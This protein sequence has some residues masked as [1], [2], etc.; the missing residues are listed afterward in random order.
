MP[1]ISV[2]TFPRRV[3]TGTQNDAIRRSFN[4]KARLWLGLGMACAAGH[5]IAQ[6]VIPLAAPTSAEQEQRR[7]E[8]R[9]RALRIQQ[10]RIPD[11]RLLQPSAVNAARFQPEAPCFVIDQLDLK[12]FADQGAGATGNWDWA[13]H[14]AAGATHDDSPLR[15]CIGTAGIDLVLKRVQD[16]VVARG[17]VTTRV[18][19]EPQDLNG[20]VLTLTV[21]PGYISA[22]RFT[23][24]S[25]TSGTHLNAVPAKPGDVLNLRDVEQA[26]EN[27]KRVPT[28]D[29]DIQ[30]E[31]AKGKD[32]QPGQ[33]DLVISYK[34]AFPVRLSIF[35]DDSGFKSTGRYQGGISLSYDNPLTLN[36]LFYVSINRDLG[37]GLSGA[38][39]THGN[40]VHYSVPLGYWLIGVTGSRSR[41]RQS[42]AGINQTYLYS[43]SSSNLEA[44]LSRLVYRDASRKTTVA[45]RAFQR[46]SSNF[47][48]DTEVMVQRRVVGGYEASVNH[49]EFIGNAT[50]DLNL[51]YRRGTGAFG[52][53]AAPE[54]A[55]GEGTSR[56]R[57]TTLDATLNLP[58]KAMSQSLR[59]TGTLRTQANHTAL[60]PQ[61][62]FAIGGRYT[63]RGFDGET[64]LLAERGVLLRN[65]LG[66]ALG[67]SGQE[68]Y[69]GVDYGYVGGPSSDLL[70][71]KSLSG[72]VLGLRGAA[73]GMQ[74][75]LFVGK[76]I[77]KP[78]AFLTSRYS[79][80]VSLSYGF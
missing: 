11:V 38:R 33:S 2:G 36:D 66:I 20:R 26:L 80:G 3:P 71:G 19:A 22:V 67:S 55:F 53:L 14:A 30:I 31:P 58:F 34:R 79:A 32:A 17:Y 23:P 44:K 61:D 29:A 25:S 6:T 76:P 75:D 60:T 59:Y 4:L 68:A 47:I 54:Q 1:N 24:E 65:D 39:G 69:A 35:A 40:T 74:Y 51:A 16:A 73:K 62:R 42:V 49:R 15:R 37:G 8:E 57:L 9:D 5:V 45:V 46:T 48:D 64:S 43:G 56:M 10:E 52:S 18:V 50:L 13:L 27:F 12:V 70:A 72:A 21:I 78:D 77:R 63:V 7:A 28:A 41:Y